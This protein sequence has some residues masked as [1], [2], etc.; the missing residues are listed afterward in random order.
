MEK[1]DIFLDFINRCAIKDKE[2]WNTFIDK[3]SSYIYLY[4]NKTL[5]RYN[6]FSQNGEAGEVFNSVFLALLDNDCK[7]LKNFRGQNEYSFLAY[8]REI[9]FHITV[10]FLRRQ[11]SFVDLEKVKNC[12]PGRDHSV[13]MEQKDLREMISI[14]RDE[15]PPRHRYLFRLIFEEELDL[16]E[17]SEIMDINL[18][19][20][21]QLKFRMIKNLIKI[22]KRKGLY[23]ELKRFIVNPHYTRTYALAGTA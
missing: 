17:I 3:Y 13:S 4:I 20:L 11:K 7:R 8:L 6:V 1:D 18:N 15:L 2:A 10:D 22:A 21:S 19:A 16:S 14:V 5:R 9:S 23:W 12:F